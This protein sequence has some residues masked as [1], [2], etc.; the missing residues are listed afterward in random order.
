MF[1]PPLGEYSVFIVADAANAD[2]AYAHGTIKITS[3]GCSV[4]IRSGLPPICRNLSK[5]K[6]PGAYTG[7]L[8]EMAPPHRKPSSP[9][10]LV[11]IHRT[12]K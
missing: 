1:N 2:D 6:R 9:L 11:A 3:R 5:K 7:P 10:T 12:G 4:S 8:F